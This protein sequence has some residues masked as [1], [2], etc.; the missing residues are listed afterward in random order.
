MAYEKPIT[1]KEAIDQIQKKKFVLPSIQREFVWES[2]QIEI[3]F[4]SV[5]RDYPI[6]TFLFWHVEKSR[7][8]EFQFYEFL[9]HYHEKNATHNPKASLADD[10][11]VIAVLDGQQRLTSLYVGLKGTYAEKVKGKRWDSQKAFPTKKLYLDLLKPSEDIDKYYSFEFLSDEEVNLST[12]SYWFQVGKILDM[13]EYPDV[14]TYLMEK[15]LTD[16]SKYDSEQ[17]KFAMTTLNKL[18]NAIHQLGIMN[19]YLEK[20]PELDKVLQIFIRTNSGGT[21]LSYSDLLLS[22]ATA[23]WQERDAREE[24]HEFV[25]ELNAIGHGFDINKDF[26]M[27]SCLVLG[28]FSDIKFRVDNFTKTNM[29]KIE[30]QWESITTALNTAVQLSASF[31]FNRENLTSNN[32]LIPIAYYLLKINANE[33]FITAKKFENDRARI[34]QWLLRVLLKRTFSGQPDSLY[35]PL[36]KLIND[37]NGEFPLQAIIENY[38]GS[39]KSITFSDEDIEA[40]CDL[41]YGGKF[42][43]SALALLYPEL[44]RNYTFHMD[45]IFPKKFFGERK[46]KKYG[47]PESEIEFY[48]TNYNNI[49]NLQLLEG[50]QNKQK[51]GTDFNEWFTGNFKTSTAKGNYKATHHLPED[52]DFDFTNFKK[53]YQQRRKLI[54]DK[55]TMILNEVK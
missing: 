30:Q 4:D 36:R 10:E 20:S 34:W 13:K 5:M 42:T 18:Y 52:V 43:F 33:S 47:I 1:I 25:D 31:G 19:F 6:S 53:V 15:G 35:P 38:R 12:G 40:L 22:I 14:M 49:A 7:I 23:Q 48:M 26:V 46:L 2:S 17:G 3:L 29:Y 41:P 9:Q 54:K 51:S 55:F 8:K 28:D 32:T 50:N 45:H 21:K 16:S 11:D 37:A 44:N 27:K 39:N 24:I